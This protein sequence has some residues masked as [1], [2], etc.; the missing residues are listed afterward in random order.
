M[1]TP[2]PLS[3]RLDLGLALA[4]GPLV[5]Q[6]S[7]DPLD[8]A[9]PAAT[10]GLASLA[11]VM[12]AGLTLTISRG[13]SGWAN[14][15]TMTA[16]AS[17]TVVLSLPYISILVGLKQV[18][19]LSS[20]PTFAIVVRSIAA[21]ILAGC[22]L[23]LTRTNELPL[24]LPLST[25][26]AADLVLSAWLLPAPVCPVAWGLAC[27]TSWPHAGMLFAVGLLL[28]TNRYSHVVLLIGFAYGLGLLALLQ[29]HFFDRMKF[30]LMNHPAHHE[31]A[32]V[33]EHRRRSHW[34]HD[35][36]LSLVAGVQMKLERDQLS[37]AEVS[38]ELSDL[39]HQLRLRQAEEQIRSG[40][41]TLGELLQPY[42][43]HARNM[44][45][46]IIE[47][48]ALET[49][50]VRLTTKDARRAQRV[51]GVTVPNAV[52]AG[53][54]TLAVRFEPDIDRR[55][56]VIQVEDNA[57]GFNWANLPP[58]RG[59]DSLRRD[60]GTGRLRF[61]RTSSGTC[62]TANLHLPSMEMS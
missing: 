14:G 16:F 1:E 46:A 30:R 43:R 45:A 47:A 59:L 55:D 61:E 9:G 11:V 22:W 32:L 7:D 17:A 42:L 54:T 38:R 33:D 31:L 49:A 24:A 35:D 29:V 26:V 60:L 50:S 56:L 52:H 25:A 58:G 12:T 36:V 21:S 13:F 23:L 19:P 48:P 6:Q 20:R 53:A 27:F 44:G 10:F 18:R 2:E 41:A 51:F 15:V 5:W 37:L 40:V 57:G 62:I 4:A 28:A 34:L 8:G 3:Q 39:D